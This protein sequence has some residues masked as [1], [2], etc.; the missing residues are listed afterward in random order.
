MVGAGESQECSLELSGGSGQR[1]GRPTDRRQAEARSHTRAIEDSVNLGRHDEIVLVQSFYLLGAQGNRHITPAEADVGV[2]A[3]G[4]GK[5]T[6]FLNKGERFSEIAESKGPLDAVG[7]VTQLPIGSLRLKAL[8]FITREWRD[9]A[10]T[11]RACLLGER[12]G[13]ILVLEPIIKAIAGVGVPNLARGRRPYAC[14]GTE[15]SGSSTQLCGAA[16]PW[17]WRAQRVRA[18]YL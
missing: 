8:G 12:L 13:H 6:D 14:E 11:R 1:N 17:K 7:I 16:F 15:R 2:M 4:L 3:F 5:L 9:A 10:A 18:G